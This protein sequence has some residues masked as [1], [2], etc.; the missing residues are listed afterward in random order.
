MYWPTKCLGQN[1]DGAGSLDEYSGNA[2]PIFDF[3]MTVFSV[4]VIVRQSGAGSAVGFAGLPIGL[5]WAAVPL[6]GITVPCGWS[7]IA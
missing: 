2:A 3:V 1:D 5:A 6:I 4:T 7:A